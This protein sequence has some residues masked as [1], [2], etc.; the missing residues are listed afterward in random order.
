[1]CDFPGKPA[2]VLLR[3]RSADI[4]HRDARTWLLSVMAFPSGHVLSWLGSRA[5]AGSGS[6]TR[7]GRYCAAGPPGDRAR[8]GRNTG[9]PAPAPGAAGTAG[10]PVR[11]LP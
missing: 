3:Y 9:F 1:M 11:L 10:M 6:I 4:L 5:A 7:S 2:L 8:R